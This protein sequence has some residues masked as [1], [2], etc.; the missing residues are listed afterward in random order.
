MQRGIVYWVPQLQTQGVQPQAIKADMLGN[1]AVQR[2]FAVGGVAHDGV[3]DV[4][5]VAAR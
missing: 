1:G 2:P 4:F 3:R 5:H